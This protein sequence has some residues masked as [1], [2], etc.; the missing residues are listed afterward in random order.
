MTICTLYYYAKKAHKAPVDF[1]RFLKFYPIKFMIQYNCI[2][3]YGDIVMSA[4]LYRLTF[5]LF[6]PSSL[7]R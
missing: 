4:D 6:L 1:F 7:K 2:L 5:G 3:N